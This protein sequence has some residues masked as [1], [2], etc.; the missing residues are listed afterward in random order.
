M[1][2]TPGLVIGTWV[3]AFDN[4]IHFNSALGTGGQLAL[5]IVGKVL[6][7]IERSPDLRQRYV[8]DMNWVQ[9]FAPDLDC[10]GRRTRSAFEEFIHD[11]FSG[12]DD[13]INDIQD[14]AKDRKELLEE[15]L[16]ENGIPKDDP[17][18][19]FFD[20]LFKKKQ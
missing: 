6:R 8:R 1:A 19:G 9:E 4:D 15:G 11:V 17:K 10:E 7:D 18:E 16:D 2:Y 20:R 13:K 5:P 3:G 14:E 12:P